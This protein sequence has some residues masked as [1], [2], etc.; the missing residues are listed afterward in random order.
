MYSGR[1]LD[2]PFMRA[3]FQVTLDRLAHLHAQ[4]AHLR[5]AEPNPANYRLSATG[6]LAETDRLQLEI[7]E[8]LSIHPTEVPA[9][10]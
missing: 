2:V 8:Y 4:L 1:M 6:F 5:Q 7:R 3:E 10:T 9:M